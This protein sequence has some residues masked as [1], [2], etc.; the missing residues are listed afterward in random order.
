MKYIPTLMKIM[1]L[2]GYSLTSQKL[3]IKCG[4]R[5]LFINLN[6]TGSEEIY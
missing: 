5:E 4:T 2:E 6:A 3:L 1:N